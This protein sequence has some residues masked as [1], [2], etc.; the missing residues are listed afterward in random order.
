MRLVQRSS[1]VEP[2]GI[3]TEAY[4]TGECFMIATASGDVFKPADWPGCMFNRKYRGKTFVAYNLRYDEGA[5]I[6]HL[7]VEALQELRLFGKTE[8]D[9]YSYRSIPKKMLSIRKGQN[10]I[11]IFDIAGFFGLSLDAASRSFLGKKKKKVAT[12][13]FTP[14]YAAANWASIADYC[15]QDAV[16]TQELAEALIAKFESFGVFPQKLYSTAYMAYQYFASTC[17][18]VTVGEYWNDNRDVLDAA[19]AAY[20]GGKFEVTEKGKDYYYEYDINSAYPY[21]IANLV[22]IRGAEVIRSTDYQSHAIYGFLKCDI[23][24]PPH[25]HNPT[26]IKLGTVNVF[27]VGRFTKVLTKQEY[28]YLVEQGSDIE[29]LAG[30]WLYQPNVTY[31]YKAEIERL[32]IEKD[33][34]KQ[35][36]RKVDYHI[37][38]IFL[39]SLYGKF[40]QLVKQGEKWRASACWNPIYGAIITANTRITITRLQQQHTCVVAVHTDS[41]LSTKPLDIPS[42]PDL[43]AMSYVTEGAGVILGSGVYQVGK[44]VRFRGFPARY[45]LLDMLDQKRKSIYITTRKPHS[46]REVLMWGWDKE[47]I[48]R[49]E[50]QTKTMSPDFDR[51]RIWPYDWT[52][53]SDVN[54]TKILSMPL[55]VSVYFGFPVETRKCDECGSR[56]QDWTIDVMLEPGKGRAEG[57]QGGTYVERLGKRHQ[58]A[59]RKRVVCANCYSLDDGGLAAWVTAQ[60]V[61]NL[62]GVP[63]PKGVAP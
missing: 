9:G 47:Y 50:D 28:D 20:S 45:S 54:D 15:I 62:Q 11:T 18:Y 43:G 6:Q 58:G 42:I 34:A 52:Y 36:G 2:I 19:M 5:F 55:A 38:K 1:S 23:T 8:E 63:S 16:L 40:I 4:T 39:N 7:S 56:T 25:V 21:E 46:W 24:I 31:P 10:A 60:R 51:K 49:F 14:I 29:I 27:P 32:Y 22:D 57:W 3:D 41:I 44:K 53:F 13:D 37:I 30:I 12:L 33:K 48:N 17:D 35:E 61:L 59:T 26:P